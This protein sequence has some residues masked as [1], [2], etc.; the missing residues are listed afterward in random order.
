MRTDAQGRPPVSASTNTHKHT[1][2]SNYLKFSRHPEDKNSKRQAVVFL[3]G[4]EGESYRLE[5][6]IVLLRNTQ[7]PGA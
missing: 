3:V 4:A 6:P 1:Q 2:S 7:T 5:Q